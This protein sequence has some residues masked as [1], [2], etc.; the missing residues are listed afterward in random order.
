MKPI[1]DQEFPELQKALEESQNLES[2]IEA[3]EWRLSQ[4]G[5]E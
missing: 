5:S 4:E 2:L 1:S 3:I